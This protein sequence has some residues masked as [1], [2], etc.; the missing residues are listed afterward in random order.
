VDNGPANHREDRPSV[1]ARPRAPSPPGALPA[2][3]QT[4]KQDINDEDWDNDNNDDDELD[5][6]RSL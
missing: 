1:G 2:T 5:E 4:P 3:S 6:I